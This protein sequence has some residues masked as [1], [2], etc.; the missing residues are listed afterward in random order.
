[1]IALDPEL[2]PGIEAQQPE[3]AL[4]IGQGEVRLAGKLEAHPPV[5][6]PADP[7]HPSRAG[8]AVPD[9]QRRAGPGGPFDECGDLLGRVL[10]I[11]IERQSPGKTRRARSRKTAAQR[12]ALAEVVS[13]PFHQR[14]GIA[15]DRAGRIRR[16]VI[17]NDHVR[18][19]NTHPPHD[20]ADGGGLV[21]AGYDDNMREG[22]VHG[23]HA[24]RLDRCNVLQTSRVCVLR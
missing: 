13:M 23:P 5:R 20:R 22:R 18:H 11:A 2:S 1:M 3:S 12:S 9:N 15:R 21:P 4:G 6:R 16:T 14:P 24:R 8:G 7:R 17:H 19:M 10:A